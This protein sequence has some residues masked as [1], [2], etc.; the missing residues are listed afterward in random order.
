MVFLTKHRFMVLFHTLSLA[1]KLNSLCASYFIVQNFCNLPKL[2]ALDLSNN[3]LGNGGK[4]A[5]CQ[6]GKK[7]N[8][9]SGKCCNHRLYFGVLLNRGAMLMQWL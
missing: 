2:S 3:F 9:L 4:E 8:F 7:D 1:Y 5:V 6:L